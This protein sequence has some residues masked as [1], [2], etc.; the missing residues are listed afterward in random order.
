[1]YIHI[2][3]VYINSQQAKRNSVLNR[4]TTNG[5]ENPYVC[6][7]YVRRLFNRRYV[8]YFLQ[9]DQLMVTDIS[10]KVIINSPETRRYLFPKRP[11]FNKILFLPLPHNKLSIIIIIAKLNSLEPFVNESYK[12]KHTQFI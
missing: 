6:L 7:F 10:Y 12:K 5:T 3:I 11:I 2:H 1:M 4:Q 9:I 8:I